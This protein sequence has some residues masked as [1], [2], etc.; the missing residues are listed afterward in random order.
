MKK[1]TI[2]QKTKQNKQTK[3]TKL[4]RSSFGVSSLLGGLKNKKKTL[5][6]M[7]TQSKK[8]LKLYLENDPICITT[9]LLQNPT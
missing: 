5:E 4:N 7:K 9:P 8:L 6:A 1:Q 3:N 2:K